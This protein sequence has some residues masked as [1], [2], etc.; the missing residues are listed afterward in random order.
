MALAAEVATRRSA[1]VAPVAACQGAPS[2]R[3]N[4]RVA[5]AP[6]AARTTHAP[7]N[8]SRRWPDRATRC[9]V[10]GRTAGLAAGA[11][12]SACCWAPSSAGGAT[13]ACCCASVGASAPTTSAA[14]WTARDTAL[15]ADQTPE[16]VE[17]RAP[18]LARR[19][20]SPEPGR[21]VP[22]LRSPLL[23]RNGVWCGAMLQRPVREVVSPVIADE[24]QC[25]GTGCQKGPLC[26]GRG[27][28]NVD[29]NS[30]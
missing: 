20:G 21:K 18:A 9:S 19:L 17:E 6:Q 14:A 13:A 29:I 8:C 4:A 10:G 30:K 16:G 7:A 26:L 12:P 2:T 15:A 3:A 25:R 28:D 11:A 23:P 22:G 27:G 5:P 1:V 24:V